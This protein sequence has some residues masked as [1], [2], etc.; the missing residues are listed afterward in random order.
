[1]TKR[2]QKANQ[3][4]NQKTTTIALDSEMHA[5]IKQIAEFEERDFGAQVR[6]IC[7]EWLE[8]LETKHAG[9]EAPKG[10]KH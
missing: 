7:R 4:T 6:V 8:Q 9:L 3:K 1:V 10:G 5:K 2:Q